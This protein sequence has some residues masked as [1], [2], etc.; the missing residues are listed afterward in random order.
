MHS[1]DEYS[2]LNSLQVTVLK[3]GTR[4]AQMTLSPK[5]AA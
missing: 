2:Q 3:Q 1:L 5:S 4:I